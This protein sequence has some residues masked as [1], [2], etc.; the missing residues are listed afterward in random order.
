[1]VAPSCLLLAGA[2]FIASLTEEVLLF[3]LKGLLNK[4]LHSEL[5][6]NGEQVTFGVH[7]AGESLLYLFANH[8]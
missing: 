8:L 5:G 6:H 3:L 7:S 2:P 4:L 1:M